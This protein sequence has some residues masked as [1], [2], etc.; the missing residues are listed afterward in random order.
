MGKS[1]QTRASTPTKVWLVAPSPP[2]YGG[3]SVQAEKL[4]NRLVSE[5]VDAELISTNQTF[6]WFLK[7][8]ERIP[9]LRTI[10]REMRYLLSL[11][12]IIRDP[13][14]VHHFSASYLYFF[15][16][17]APLLLLGRW[18]AVK[19]VL[20]YRGGKAEEFLRSWSWAALP[21]LKGSDHVLVPSVFLQRVFQDFG[22][23][24]TILPNLAD[25]ELFP[26]V[27]REQFSPRLFV[28]RN[29]EPMYDVEC[30]LRAFQRIQDKAPRAELGIAG[31]GSEA[32]RLHDLAQK[33]GL[34]GVTFYGP[35]PHAELP[36]LYQQHDIYI[37]ASRVD[38]FP[39]AL[40]EAACAGLPIVTTRAGGIREM[41]RHRENG[42]LCAVG[43]A[44]AL[45]NSVLEIVGHPELGRELART[46]LS[47]AEPFSWGNVFP[48]LRQCY[49]LGSRESLSTPEEHRIL[50]H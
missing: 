35:V 9:V 44:E 31:G 27:R 4:R 41:I 29:L 17:S 49:G 25:T 24:S 48:Q 36:S 23:A 13:G 37:N 38:N 43:D 26:F 12:R 45:A 22:V 40:I 20:N 33:W 39:G 32:S 1:P 2:P 11:A 10:L 3:M 16:H 30:V 21:L 42:M 7:W 8:V 6:P 5:G 47:W 15:L 28:S 14:V 50:V 18:S 34:R 19:V 46:A